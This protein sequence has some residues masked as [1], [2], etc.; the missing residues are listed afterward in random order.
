MSEDPQRGEES[1]LRELEREE[2]RLARLRSVIE[3]HT[4][5]EGTGDAREDFDPDPR[6]AA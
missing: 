6:E 2:R 4:G 3:L 5:S 1:A